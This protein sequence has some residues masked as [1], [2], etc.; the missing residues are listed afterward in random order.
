MCGIAGLY[1]LNDS[2]LDIKDYISSAISNLSHRGPDDFGIDELINKRLCLGHT[3]LAIQDLTSSGHQP[4]K[5]DDYT[6][7]FNGE[8]YNCLELKAKINKNLKVEWF[9]SSDTEVI[10]KLY[11]YYSIYN[12][13]LKDFHNELNGIF[14][15]AIWDAKK[16]HLLVS[17]DYLGVKPLYYSIWNNGF[18]FASEIKALKTLIPEIGQ[19]NIKAL[20]RYLSYIYSPG[21][22][23]PFNNINKFSPGEYM[24]IRD[25]KV[26]K[27]NNWY[28][29]TNLKH[30]KYIPSKNKYD[31][32]FKDLYEQLERAV[33]RQMISDA[34]LG[35]FLSGGLD[36]SSIV[37]IASNKEPNINCFTIDLKGGQDEGFVDDIYYAKKV[38]NFFQLNLDV[39]NIS[40]EDIIKNLSFMV[41]MLDEPLADPAALNI[42]FISKLARNKGIKVLLSG[43]GGDDILTGYR[44]HQAINIY[45]YLDYLP[46]KFRDL[47]RCKLYNKKINYSFIR[48]LK[49]LIDCS[50]LHGDERLLNHFRWTSREDISRLF[51]PEYSKQI[52]ASNIDKP[53]IEF[54]ESIPNEIG[55]LEKMLQ[56]EQNFF[57]PDHNLLYTDKMSMATGVEVR[58]PFLDKEFL[59]YSYQIPLKFKIRDLKTKWPLKKAMEGILPKK[60]IYRPKTGFGVPLR[61]W[62]KNEMKEL[63]SDILSAQSLKSRGI[64]NYKEVHKLLQDNY[65]D[66]IDASYTI[67]SIVCIELWCRNFIDI[68]PRLNSPDLNF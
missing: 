37:A 21:K 51:L 5:F 19:I 48:R 29:T 53:L 26:T 49:H 12:L 64:F 61:R 33:H 1:L 67:F 20:G 42:F 23:T 8:I 22:E 66:R 2:G 6:I 16:S 10:L 58:V 60:V 34:P 7:V 31:Y 50:C 25:G 24:I 3:R 41:S 47:I 40:S 9:S 59:E 11:Q 27:K 68:S 18:A 4:M 13:D 36:S 62:I 63:I 52:S 35:A 46:F 54:L 45:N 39:V 56:L 65:D 30:K 55:D 38:A 15:F 32:K 43:T 14:S 28:K 57:L 44:R 17:R